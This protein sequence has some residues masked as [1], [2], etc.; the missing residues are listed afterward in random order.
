MCDPTLAMVGLNAAGTMARIGQQNAAAEANAR[1]AISAGN[2]EMVS[3]HR[4]Y[5]ED[6]R[7]LIQQGMDAVL[8]GRSAESTAYTSAIQSGVRGASVRAVM[9]DKRMTMGRNTRRTSLELDS[10]ESAADARGR[11]VRAKVKGRIAQ[12]PGTRFGLGDAVSILAPIPK[13]G[14]NT[15]RI[16]GLGD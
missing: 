6:S 15:L 8:Q 9:R 3:D 14:S 12:V 7:S 4:R 10:L 13:Y 1:Q 2:T 5:I 16:N 11:E